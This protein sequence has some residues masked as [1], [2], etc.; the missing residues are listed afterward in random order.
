MT[1]PVLVLDG[2]QAGDLGLVRSLGLAG[3]PVHLLTHLVDGTTAASR[4]VT[5]LKAFP[6]PDSPPDQQLEA[7][8]SAA[9]AVGG[10]PPVMMAG[11]RS[12]KLISD[13]REELAGMLRHDLPAREVVEACYYKDRFGLE[14]IRLGLPVPRTIVADSVESVR[15]FARDI[16]YPVF[17]KPV[18]KDV[19]ERGRLPPGVVAGLKGQRVDRP[20]DLV[21]LFERLQPHGADSAVV[22]EL[23]ESPDSEHYSVHAYV[24][25]DGSFV[26]AFTTRKLR[27]HPPHRGIGSCVRS[28]LVPELVTMTQSILARLSYTGFALAQFKRHVAD[29]RFFLLEINC[30]F[31]TSGELPARCGANFPEISYAELM[32]LPRPAVSQTTGAC[33]I[34][35]GADL[36]AMR[37]YRQLGEWTWPAFVAS[38]TDVRCP[39]YLALDDPRPFARRIRDRLRVR[40]EVRRSR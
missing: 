10:R 30:R 35:L 9:L 27:V 15:G 1:V 8:R 32:D 31:S 6:A 4:Y 3:I 19:W 24:A 2:G 28:E 17:V 13:H 16:D 33:W 14:A 18:T 20:E 26:G 39:A 38:L 21:A 37:E 23:V 5:E 7:L 40:R 25:P 29:G 34:D 12:L 22:Q 11:D 36:W